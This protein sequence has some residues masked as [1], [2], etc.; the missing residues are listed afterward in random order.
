[1]GVVGLFTPLVV[2][3]YYCYIESWTLAW[4]WFSVTGATRGLDEAGMRAFLHSYQDLGNHSV[5][6]FW[7]P[8]VFFF[9]TISI[10]FAVVM[11][12]LSGGI[13][14]L[15]KIGMPILFFFA[16]ILVVRVLTLHPQAVTVADGTGAR[17]ARW[18]A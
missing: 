1:M 15:A 9:I 8:F 5:H 13:E 16:A 4:T 7:T 11:K 2:L 14:K 3:I 17:P 18:T 12:G 10:N 6:G